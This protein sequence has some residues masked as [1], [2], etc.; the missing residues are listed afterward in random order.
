VIRAGGQTA[1]IV[2][3]GTG[4]SVARLV[5]AAGYDPSSYRI[6]LMIAQRTPCSQ[7]R[8]H[9]AI[10]MRLFPYLTAARKRLEDCRR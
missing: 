1:A 3:A 6:H 9:A 7:A 4:R 5:G 10:A 2:H 8:S